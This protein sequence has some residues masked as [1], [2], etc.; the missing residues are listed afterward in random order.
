MVDN[1]ADA[2]I[3]GGPLLPTCT[4]PP[5]MVMGPKKS[6]VPLLAMVKVPAP[7]FVRLAGPPILPGP[8]KV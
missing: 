5:L 3:A 8:V 7:S 6:F 2:E 1:R 4:E